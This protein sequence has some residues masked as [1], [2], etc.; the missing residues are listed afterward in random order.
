MTHWIQLKLLS[1]AGDRQLFTGMWQFNTGSSTAADRHCD[2]LSLTV[3]SHPDDSIPLTLHRLPALAL[4]P[5][6]WT[7]DTGVWLRANHLEVSFSQP[8]AQRWVSALS[9]THGEE[10]PRRGRLRQ[11]QAM[12]INTCIHLTLET[13]ST[14]THT[15][16]ASALPQTCIPTIRKRWINLS[17]VPRGLSGLTLMTRRGLHIID[18]MPWATEQAASLK[19]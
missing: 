6:P 3:L 1:W 14:K 19:F 5:E 11:L 4:F 9:T 8:S 7:G 15:C 18:V 17:H 10:K 2:F 16:Q 12:D 13:V